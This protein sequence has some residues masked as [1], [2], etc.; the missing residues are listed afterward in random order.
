MFRQILIY[1]SIYIGLFMG[2]FYILSMFLS[3]K[4]EPEI[5]KKLP[6]VSIII[7]AYNEEEGIEGSIKGALDFDYPKDK[8]EIIVVDDGSMDNTYERAK[9]VENSDLVKVYKLKQNQGKGA[10]MNYGIK[11]S[12]GEIV[13]TM[14][15]DN[16]VVTKDVLKKV[17]SYFDSDSIKCV[18]PG[19]AIYKPRGI[20]Q[21]V[22]QIEY[23]AG[24]FLRKAFSS[25]NSIPIT[26]GAFSAYKRDFFEE[27]GFFDEDNLTEDMEMTLRIQYHHYVVK[28]NPNAIVYTHAPNKFKELLA[29][30]RRWYGGMMDNIWKYRDMFS[31]EYGVLGVLVLPLIVFSTTIALIIPSWTLITTLSKL[32]GEIALW[33]SINFNIL[34]TVD[35]Q[36][37]ALETIFFSIIS[38]PLTIFFSTTVILLVCYLHYGKSKVKEH[39]NIK[40]SIFFFLAFFLML[41][42]FWWL[43]TI[44]Y[45]LFDKSI[46]W[47]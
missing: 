4:E 18:F 7:P 25:V 41:H 23:L 34:S 13:V 32:R 26:P 9:K 8:L 37:Y 12:N 40:L 38:E 14:D 15:A 10:A 30:R 31:S 11:K 39:S 47:R 1:I 17:V 28:N 44:F 5:P 29:Q 27:Y 46:P 42:S 33:Q 16:V 6:E 21:R 22:Q 20:L 19:I 3:K 43:V 36:W 2:S 45:K 35:F 24:V